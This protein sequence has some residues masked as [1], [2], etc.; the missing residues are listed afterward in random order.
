[1]SLSETAHAKIN[2]TL[3]VTGRRADG[4]HI[5]DS[6]VVFPDAADTLSYVPSGSPL[7]LELTGRFG[8]TLAGEA[9]DDNLVMRGARLLA[10]GRDVEQ[11]GR[12]ILEKN[13]PVA[14]GIGGGSADA[15]ATLR[16]LDR[17]WELNTSTER[18]HR[19]ATR[20][21]ADVP[22]CLAQKPALMSGI[23]EQLAPAPTLPQCGMILINCG[24]P[25]STPAVFRARTSAF[26]SAATFPAAWPDARAMAT[27][28]GHLTNDLEA[29]ACEI[30][31]AIR[32]VL[33]IIAALPGCLLSR[34]S[35][36]GATCF[37]LFVSA[38]AARAAKD[39]LGS[40]PAAE[41]WWIHA[42]SLSF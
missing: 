32:T 22:V 19:I 24:E 17:A 36:S 31:P 25:V 10:D 16:L 18:L 40:N 41:S 14:S 1:M 3:H 20:L 4:Y 2:L 13:L 11:T 23:G 28:L 5:L 39:R 6:L 38:E 21:G 33:T 12:L 7:S 26:S 30:C 29:P 34:M 37:G 42:G 35:G 9:S 15:A 27:D 8:Q